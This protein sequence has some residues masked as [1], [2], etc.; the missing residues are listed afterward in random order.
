MCLYLAY[1]YMY[2]KVKRLLRWGVVCKLR[3]PLKQNTF[4]NRLKRKEYANGQNQGAVINGNNK[5]R[6]RVQSLSCY[7]KIWLITGRVP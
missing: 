7:T 2:D 4:D 1:I 6:N 5:L 3:N